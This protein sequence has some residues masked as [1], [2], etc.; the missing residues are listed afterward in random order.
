[1]RRCC[2]L[3]RSRPL[4]LPRKLLCQPI[5]LL[6]V[7]TVCLLIHKRSAT[8][9]TL[10]FSL[11][12]V[13]TTC[14]SLKEG[15]HQRHCSCGVLVP[16]LFVIFRWTM[17]H[18]GHQPG[19]A[20]AG[21]TDTQPASPEPSATAHHM[22]GHPATF[23]FGNHLQLLFSF[24]QI[25]STISELGQKIPPKHK[26][27]SFRS[28]IFL[29]K[30]LVCVCKG[31]VCSAAGVSGGRAGAGLCLRGSQVGQTEAAAGQGCQGQAHPAARAAGP[32]RPACAPSPAHDHQVGCCCEPLPAE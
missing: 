5:G 12:G 21:H 27:G 29:F 15:G 18:E 22:M 13:K 7:A 14:S 26:S 1:M 20:H 10:S 11:L 4:R 19:T 32:G 6:V 28:Y 25:D 8:R 17:S 16:T 2:A 3:P 31:S 30:C 24:W 23:Y 9:D